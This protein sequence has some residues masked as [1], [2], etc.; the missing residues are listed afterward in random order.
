MWRQSCVYGHVS[1]S[2]QGTDVLRLQLQAGRGGVVFSSAAFE[3]KLGNVI[4][5]NDS[6]EPAV[7]HCCFFPDPLPSYSHLNSNVG[8]GFSP[9]I[10]FSVLMMILIF[11]PYNLTLE[12]KN[13]MK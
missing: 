6:H 2:H 4:V 10:H 9:L 1:F 8:L 7:F 12:I 11:F 3:E 13:V 5:F